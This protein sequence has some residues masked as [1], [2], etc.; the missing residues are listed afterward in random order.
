MQLWVVIWLAAGVGAVAAVWSIYWAIRIVPV[1][2]DGELGLVLGAFALGVLTIPLSF[3]VGS[4]YLARRMQ[5]GDRLARLMAIVVYASAALAFILSGVRD[6]A[7]VLVGIGCLAAVALLTI[8]PATKAHF[9]GESESDHGGPPTVVAARFLMVIVAGCIAIVGLMFL[10]FSTID[11]ALAIGGLI[12]VGVAALLFWLSRQ[13]AHGN[14][15]ARVVSSGLALVYLVLNLLGGNEQPGVILPVGIAL[16]I[17]VLL[18]APAASARFFEVQPPPVQPAIAG[19]DRAV[20]GAIARVNPSAPGG[21]LQG[22]TMFSPQPAP[23]DRTPDGSSHPTASAPPFAGPYAGAVVPMAPAIPDPSMAAP[24]P[25][26]APVQGDPPSPGSSDP[27]VG[28]PPMAA[29]P[30]SDSP[31]PPVAQFPDPVP[32]EASSVEGAVDPPAHGVPEPDAWGDPAGVTNPRAAHPIVP[33]TAALGALV[34]ILDLVLPPFFGSYGSKPLYQLGLVHLEYLLYQ[35]GRVLHAHP[36]AFWTA[37]AALIAALVAGITA[38]VVAATRG[39]RGTW[40]LLVASV[41]T[42]VAAVVT[43]QVTNDLTVSRMGVGA[44][45]AVAAS[46]LLALAAAGA[47]AAWSSRREVGHALSSLAAVGI[48]VLAVM[49]VPA[50]RDNGSGY[51]AGGGSASSPSPAAGGGNYSNGNSSVGGATPSTAP[52]ATATPAGPLNTTYSFT[53]SEAGGYTF[54]GTLELGSP[55]QF[56]SGSITEGSLTAGSACS[57]NPQTDAVIPAFLSVRNTSSGNF[58]A[59]G[60]VDLQW[61]S[62]AIGG[63]EV[64]YS[65][66]PSCDGSGSGGSGTDEVNLESTNPLTP[67]SETSTDLFVWVPDYYSPNNPQGDPSLLAGADLQLVEYVDSSNNVDIVPQSVSGPGASSSNGF[68]IPVDNTAQAAPPQGQPFQIT[69]DGTPVMTTP[70][71]SGTQVGTLNGGDNVT[72]LCTTQGDSVGGSTLWDQITSPAGYVPDSDVN[73]PA[74]GGLP[75]CQ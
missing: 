21:G 50:L 29:G 35:A 60:G 14:R 40:V 52:P 51:A 71:M 45:G 16:G 25:V 7:T 49:A 41:A 58:N 43:A 10:A 62:S 6:L 11:V 26:P 55:Q 13:L 63:I 20:S 22:A 72:V 47:R 28:D 34:L 18:W 53:E 61:S 48:V 32:Y 2:G 39:R 27:P 4:I 65:S 73:T 23:D 57:M 30:W 59:I 15:T 9:S 54:S 1:L 70:S 31:V 17:V 67:G 33:I 68:T 38:V 12:Q 24:A 44:W 5:A 46:L 74:G 8:D 42:G 66:G 19:I 64:G 3:G 37:G 75:T 36:A 69:S 56:Q